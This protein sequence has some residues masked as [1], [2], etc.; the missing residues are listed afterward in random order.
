V[1]TEPEIAG[2][3]AEVAAVVCDPDNAPA[4]YEN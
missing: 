4:W 3:R 2:P 1:V